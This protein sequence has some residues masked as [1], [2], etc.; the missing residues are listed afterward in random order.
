MKFLFKIALII[1]LINGYFANSQTDTLIVSVESL[2]SEIEERNPDLA[3]MRHGIESY[4][5]YRRQAGLSPNPELSVEYNLFNPTNRRWFSTDSD[6]QWALSLMQLFE[7]AGKRSK[8]IQ[9]AEKA[10]ESKKIEY[11]M[12]RR[13]YERMIRN[14]ANNLFLLSAQFELLNSG[15][16]SLQETVESMDRQFEIGNISLSELLRVKSLLFRLLDERKEI[17]NEIN[18]IQHQIRIILNRNDNVFRKITNLTIPDEQII[19]LEVDRGLLEA[20]IAEKSP[21]IKYA[22]SILAISLSELELARAEA[23]PDLKVGIAFDRYG[24]IGTNYSALQFELDLPLFNRNQGRIQAQRANA[25]QD[26][27]L[28]ES[29]RNQL[30]HE[31]QS[32][33][34]KFEQTRV[35]HQTLSS[36]LGGNT[37]N[38]LAS[39][40]ENYR[41]RNISVIEFTD[42]YETFNDNFIHLFKLKREMLN[43]LEIINLHTENY[44]N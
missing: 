14:S 16:N 36:F 12:L 17:L 27:L 8:R 18:E 20:R 24:S 34:T 30:V 22:E 6:T 4:A 43:Y 31:I 35:T 7:T 40:L 3:A 41:R 42:L 21:H 13:E 38:L 44:I 39:I 28:L 9:T 11:Y 26:R 19:N 32:L 37:L 33:I 2:L 23:Y 1:I 29:I 10:I 25:E 15:I 5:G